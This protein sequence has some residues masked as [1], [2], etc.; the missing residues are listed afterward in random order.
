MMISITFQNLSTWNNLQID[1]P[2]VLRCSNSYRL[3]KSEIAFYLSNHID[4]IQ[5]LFKVQ[6]E[7]DILWFPI[8]TE[9]SD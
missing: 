5:Y 4:N 9:A 1:V 8:Y 6:S 2:L 3:H 7:Q